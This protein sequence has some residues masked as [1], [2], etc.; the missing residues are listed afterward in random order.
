MLKH[1]IKIIAISPFLFAPVAHAQAANACSVLKAHE[2]WESALKKAHEKYGISAGAIMSVIDQESRF[3]A[4]AK[5][6]PYFGYAQ[7]SPQTWGWFQGATGFN[8]SRSDFATSAMFV[9]WH[10]KTMNKNLG[11][12]MGNISQQYLA[13]KK[14]EFGY[15][16]GGSSHDRAVSAKVAARAAMFS[17]QL[18]NCG[19]GTNSPKTV[20]PKSDVQKSEASKKPN[21]SE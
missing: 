14:G 5:N 4:N 19:F 3:K 13:Y 2:N 9:G 16:K 18:K 6:G 15:K 7:S 12:P 1:L 11:I 20:A 10:F 8:G 17:A 21:L